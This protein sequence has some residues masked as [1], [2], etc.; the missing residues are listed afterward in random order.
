MPTLLFAQKT[1]KVVDKTTN[2]I[3]YILKS[4]K[5]SNYYVDNPLGYG[6]DEEVIRVMKL[7][8]DNWLPGQLNGQ[9]IDVEIAYPFN[10]RLN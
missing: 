4:D 1:K 5:T 10:F 3:F 7:I 8:P 9:P 6:L 2:E